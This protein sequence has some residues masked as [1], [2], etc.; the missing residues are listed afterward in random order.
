M[1]AVSKTDALALYHKLTD[2]AYG[3][4]EAL[5]TTPDKCGDPICVRWRKLEGVLELEDGMLLLLTDDNDPLFVLTE[6]HNTGDE[7]QGGIMSVIE[8]D[9]E[10]V[11]RSDRI[12]TIDY[13]DGGVEFFEIH[14]GRADLYH[15]HSAGNRYQEHLLFSPDDLQD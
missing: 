2:L 8:N 10:A 3:F 7:K 6:Y 15:F 14:K 13:K 5:G 9:F 11:H 1:K 12:L 4:A